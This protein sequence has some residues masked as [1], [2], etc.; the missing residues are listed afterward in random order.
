M[1]NLSFSL[2]GGMTRSGWYWPSCAVG[3]NM[4]TGR[5]LEIKKETAIK[6]DCSMFITTILKKYI[7]KN[8]GQIVC[9]VDELHGFS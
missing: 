8:K 4:L 9:C 2:G 3:Q 5:P 1:T 6:R 7:L